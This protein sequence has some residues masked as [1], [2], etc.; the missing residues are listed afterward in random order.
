MRIVRSEPIV[1]VAEMPAEPARLFVCSQYR[2][3]FDPAQRGAPS[4][5]VELQY[6]V[7]RWHECKVVVPLFMLCSLQGSGKCGE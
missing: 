3:S 4:L 7:G 6:L 1:L 5:S 2:M